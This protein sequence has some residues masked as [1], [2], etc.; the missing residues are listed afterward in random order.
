[1][2]VL[3]CKLDKVTEILGECLD[4]AKT[5]GLNKFFTSLL[6]A[7]LYDA[8]CAASN[9]RNTVEWSKDHA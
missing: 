4:L 1:M 6:E 3:L 8:K 5:I 7:S 9:I 2:E